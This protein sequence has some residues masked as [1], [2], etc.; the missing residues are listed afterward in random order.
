MRRSCPVPGTG[1]GSVVHILLGFGGP[2]RRVTTPARPEKATAAR[3][4]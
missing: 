3:A 4:S 1:P 2:A